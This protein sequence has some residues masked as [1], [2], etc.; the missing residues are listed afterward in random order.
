ME[1][2]RSLNTYMKKTFGK[3]VYKISLSSGL[4]CPN[5]DGT[6][7]LD[8]CVFCADGSGA[9]CERGDIPL[10]LEN[11]KLRLKNKLK[12]YSDVG[13]VAYFQS[14]TNTYGELSYL[15]RIFTEAIS[16]PQVVALS[17]A[18]RPD[19][20]ED[21]KIALLKELNGIKPVWVELGLQTESDLSAKLINRAYPT[22]TYVDC[23]RRL[24][25]AGIDL[26]THLIIGLWGED[27]AQLIRSVELAG[28]W[29]KGVK[30]QLLHVLKGTPLE[31]MG[32]ETLEL[33]EYLRRLA[34]CVEHL[35]PEVI[36][37][38]LTGDGDRKKLVAPLWSA[39][40]KMVLGAI[41]S[42]FEEKDVIQGRYCEK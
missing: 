25:E 16:D 6:L 4:G 41:S 31:K 33:G 34:L 39:D 11:A 24:R 28:R 15:R 37:H 42:Y 36:I 20:L 22:E 23:A 5:R 40:K 32:W 2:Y 29:S 13:Y 26:I 30:L 3:K 17:I 8:G 12:N 27:D 9:F 1:R 7:S 14:Y 38:R 10:Q 21:E 19:C 35:P 18:T